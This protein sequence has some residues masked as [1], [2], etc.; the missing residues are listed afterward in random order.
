[1]ARPD[2]SAR[3]ITSEGWFKTGDI[4]VN[5]DGFITMADR[6]KELILSGGFNVYPSQVEEAIR[7][8]PAVSDVAV[9]G[10]PVSDATEEV[11]A[12]IIMED[13]SSPLT[14]EEVRTWAEKTI[15]HYALPRQLVI[16]AELPRN[17]MGKILRRK[18]AQLVREALGR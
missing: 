17:Q 9:V 16:I 1:M 11:T 7:S 15:A 10:V 14:L 13:G 3:V 18:V 8:H 6:K 5:N 12:A 2:E 4:G